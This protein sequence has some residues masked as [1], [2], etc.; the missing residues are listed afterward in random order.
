MS[1]EVENKR[2]RIVIASH[3]D[4]FGCELWDLETNKHLIEI[5][6]ND[7][8]KKIQFYSA[9]MD[10]PFEIIEKVIETFYKVIGRSFQERN[11]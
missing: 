9:E 6:R 5:S 10:V 7:A 2:Y 1:F 4:G 3:D 11:E 8:L